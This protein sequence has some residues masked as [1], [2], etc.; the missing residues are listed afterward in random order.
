[1]THYQLFVHFV[2]AFAS[3]DLR[4]WEEDPVFHVQGTTDLWQIQKFTSG[5]FGNQVHSDRGFF[6]LFQAG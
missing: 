4:T 1:M 3:S 6:R 2:F 5:M